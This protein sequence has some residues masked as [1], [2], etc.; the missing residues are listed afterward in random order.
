MK[1]INILWDT[2]DSE[3][4]VLPEEIDIPDGMTDEEEISDYLSNL[5]GY[6]HKG[7]ALIDRN[8]GNDSLYTVRITA[9]DAPEFYGQIIDVFEDF[10]AEKGIQITDEK[11]NDDRDDSVNTAIIFGSDYDGIR[12][13]LESIMQNWNENQRKGEIQ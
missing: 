6:C 9:D 8:E 7:F 12:D 13:S 5:T 4:T 11:S 10:L 1:A 3:E 2:E